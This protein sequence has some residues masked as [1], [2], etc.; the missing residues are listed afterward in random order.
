MASKL[1]ESNIAIN[2][3]YLGMVLIALTNAIIN[4]ILR[5]KITPISTVLK[6]HDRFLNGNETSYATEISVDK[7]Y[8]RDYVPFADEAQKW[9]C[10]IVPKLGHSL[11][12]NTSVDVAT[13][14]Q[15]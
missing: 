12:Q 14:R 4:H 13:I 1:Q 8:L 5:D 6:A 9:V 3:V 2:Y 11:G 10:I 7:I 15:E